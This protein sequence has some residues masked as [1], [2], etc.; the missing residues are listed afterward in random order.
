MAVVMTGWASA[1]AQVD[2]PGY[3]ETAPNLTYLGFTWIFTSKPVLLRQCSKLTY[4]FVC[5]SHTNCSGSCYGKAVNRLPKSFEANWHVNIRER[6]PPIQNA[7]NSVL[8][9]ANRGRRPL[10]ANRF[11]RARPGTKRTVLGRRRLGTIRRSFAFVIP[12]IS[13]VFQPSSKA[14]LT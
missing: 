8:A 14:T 11:I 6:R 4:T 10:F 3:H 7:V 13:E 2:A 12:H 5:K 1:V 9:G